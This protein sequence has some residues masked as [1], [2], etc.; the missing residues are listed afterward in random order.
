MM[1]KVFGQQDAPKGPADGKRKILAWGGK[2][3]C[4]TKKK[5]DMIINTKNCSKRQNIRKKA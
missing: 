3:A 1:E 4:Q 2:R 5:G